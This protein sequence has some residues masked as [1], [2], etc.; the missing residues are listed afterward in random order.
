MQVFEDVTLTWEGASYLIPSN[1]VMGAIAR[2]E[3]VLTLYELAEASKGRGIKLSHL[4]QAFATALRYAGA[5]ITDEEV[6]QGLFANA[7]TSATAQN[8]ILGL[9]ALMT[10]P[11]ISREAI[12]K[13]A[14]ARPLA[15][16]AKSSRKRSKPRISGG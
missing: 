6:F 5:T 16:G 8:V 4:A 3:D 1:R 12:K 11:N 2:I 13:A 10:P 7:N 14:T 15:Q 9:L